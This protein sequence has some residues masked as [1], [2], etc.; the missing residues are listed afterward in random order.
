LILVS[1]QLGLVEREINE[2]LRG[3]PAAQGVHSGANARTLS[4][5]VIKANQESSAT[6]TV[7]QREITEDDVCPICQD[8]LLG[9]HLP[10]TFCK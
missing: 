3:L 5:G 7:A 1:W 10:V 8:E 4:S 6:G 9:K 2:I